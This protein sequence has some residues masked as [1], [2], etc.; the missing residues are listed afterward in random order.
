MRLHKKNTR[1]RKRVVEVG[2][3]KPEDASPTSVPRRGMPIDRPF[4]MVLHRMAF[5]SVMIP[6]SLNTALIRDFY[7]FPVFPERSTDQ[8]KHK[9]K[10]LVE[11][12]KEHIVVMTAQGEEERPHCSSDIDQTIFDYPKNGSW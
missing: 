9:V 7:P 2:S 6:T 11:K 3:E 12:W 10:Y 8:P 1:N 5:G 4:T